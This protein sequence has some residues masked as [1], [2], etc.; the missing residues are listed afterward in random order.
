MSNPEVFI[1][2]IFFIF[3]TVFAFLL[4]REFFCWYHKINKRIALMEE[5]IRLLHDIKQNTVKS[6]RL[7]NSTPMEQ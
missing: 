3:I 4:L 1:W 7:V 5:I 2:I 6:P